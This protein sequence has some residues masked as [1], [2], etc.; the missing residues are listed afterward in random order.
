MLLPRSSATIITMEKTEKKPR[1]QTDLE[2]E[3]LVEAYASSVKVIRGKL[4]PGLTTDSKKKAWEAITT[5]VNSVSIGCSRTTDETKKT[6]QDVQSSIKK[7]EAFRKR[8]AMKTGG[9]PLTEVQLKPWELVLLSTIPREAIHG[10]EDGI[11]TGNRKDK[12]R[13]M[14]YCPGEMGDS[15]PKESKENISE[16]VINIIP[17]PV[18]EAADQTSESLKKVSTKEKSQDSSR[19]KVEQNGTFTAK[20]HGWKS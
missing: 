3:V 10:I 9:G 5:K 18:Q 7:K 14:Q 13:E 6:V 15:C 12:T 16:S 20:I 8:E 2:M 1:K 11:D 19:R 4:S 17:D